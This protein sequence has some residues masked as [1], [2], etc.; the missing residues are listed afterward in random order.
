MRIFSF[1]PGESSHHTTL[2][3]KAAAGLAA[4]E[5]NVC[6]A[7]DREIPV[8]AMPSLSFPRTRTRPATGSR[9]LGIGSQSARERHCQPV[10]ASV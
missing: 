8:G 9:K 2:A 10:L 4:S 5:M 1:D 3:G 6:R 7:V